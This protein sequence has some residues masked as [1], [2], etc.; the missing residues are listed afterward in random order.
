MPK[1]SLEYT[2]KIN[3]IRIYLIIQKF[4]KPQFKLLP[5]IK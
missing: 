5:D 3:Y 2:K 1:S 4:N